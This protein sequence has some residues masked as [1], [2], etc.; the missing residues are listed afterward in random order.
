MYGAMVPQVGVLADLCRLPCR[1]TQVSEYRDL[2]HPTFTICYC[3]LGASAGADVA[4]A[5]G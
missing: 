4:G 2:W 3:D 1:T 5:A